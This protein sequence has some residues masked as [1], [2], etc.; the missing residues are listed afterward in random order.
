MP[1]K[2]LSLTSKIIIK[3]IILSIVFIVAVLKFG[4]CCQS[5]Y[6]TTNYHPTSQKKMF[7]YLEKYYTIKFPESMANIEVAEAYGGFDGSSSFILKFKIAPDE[8]DVFLEQFGKCVESFI[9]YT[10]GADKRVGDRYPDWFKS[11]IENGRL[12]EINVHG[13]NAS[14]PTDIYIDTSN[15]NI[16][17]IYIKGFYK[18]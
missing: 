5:I 11:Q 3:L 10:S 1:I 17:V 9:P 12:G 14:H 16:Y 18:I 13:F 6:F 7:V 15:V 2:R 8:F 4:S